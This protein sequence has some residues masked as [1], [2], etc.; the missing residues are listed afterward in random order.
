MYLTSTKDSNSFEKIL[1]FRLSDSKIIYKFKMINS[2]QI[3]GEQ[4]HITNFIKLREEKL[5]KERFIQSKELLKILNKQL[6][7][8]KLEV[9]S[10]YLL[11]EF[12]WELIRSQEVKAAEDW[13]DNK[14]WSY[15]TAKI[16]GFKVNDAYKFLSKHPFLKI[17]ASFDEIYPSYWT[18]TQELKQDEYKHHKQKI[19]EHK[20]S[21]FIF[22][23]F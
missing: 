17:K 18:D 22:N 15:G 9:L 19:T 16:V 13:E 12:G 3:W 2:Y 8:D 20:N 7:K 21:K 6:E 4:E 23:L 1:I 5:L 11:Y 14:I 10:D